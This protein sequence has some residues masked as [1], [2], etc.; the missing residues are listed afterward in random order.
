MSPKN[1]G[2]DITSCSE[3]D[4]VGQGGRFLGS[5]LLRQRADV[6]GAFEALERQ[7]PLFE[8]SRIWVHD[9]GWV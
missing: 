9:D 2:L 7:G 4:H 3:V 1:L 5:I 8:K 6:L